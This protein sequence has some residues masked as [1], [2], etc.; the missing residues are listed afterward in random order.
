MSGP[1]GR[2]RLI[3]LFDEISSVTLYR[4]VGPQSELRQH[5]QKVLVS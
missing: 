1:L 3:E 4:Y 5:G 2:K